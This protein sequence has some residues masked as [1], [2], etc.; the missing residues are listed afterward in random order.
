MYTFLKLLG[1]KSIR[2]SG[3]MFG[4]IYVHLKLHGKI[5]HSMPLNTPILLNCMYLWSA[6]K[7]GQFVCGF[8]RPR[9][10]LYN[11]TELLSG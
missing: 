1:G 5:C 3:G 8:L 9:Q 4:Y 6:Y 11:Y 2:I 7:C 10:A